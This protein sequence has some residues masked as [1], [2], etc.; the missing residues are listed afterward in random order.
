MTRM[1][2]QKLST[3]GVEDTLGAGVPDDDAA[4]AGVG[5]TGPGAHGPSATRGVARL[6]DS[7]PAN[8][9]VVDGVGGDVFVARK[10]GAAVPTAAPTFA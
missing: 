7:Q 4:R 5:R 9:L 2:M 3:Q 8:P 10:Q 6:V 1:A